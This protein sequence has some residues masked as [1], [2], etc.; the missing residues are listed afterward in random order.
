MKLI[1]SLFTRKE[2][3]QGTLSRK[4]CDAGAKVKM[5]L[6]CPVL[7]GCELVEK[8]L[9]FTYQG[10]KMVWAVN[11]DGVLSLHRDQLDQSQ[12]SDYHEVWSLSNCCKSNDKDFVIELV[13]VNEY[14]YCCCNQGRLTVVDMSQYDTGAPCQELQWHVTHLCEPISCF[15]V[16]PLDQWNV[17]CGGY[18]NNLQLYNLITPFND[19][20][21]HSLNYTI[22]TKISPYWMASAHSRKSFKEFEEFPWI[23]DIVFLSD[24][25]SRSNCNLCCVTQFGKILFY[26]TDISRYCVNELI[27]S[28]HRIRNLVKLKTG[29]DLLFIDSFGY[30]GVLRDDTLL[31]HYQVPNFGPLSGCDVLELDIQQKRD[32]E[33]ENDLL[34]LSAKRQSHVHPK[35]TGSGSLN[36]IYLVFST[37]LGEI[38]MIKL[39]NENDKYDLKMSLKMLKIG[40]YLPI[41]KFDYDTNELDE[42]KLMEI[43]ETRKETEKRVTR[44]H[45]IR[46]INSFI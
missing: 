7:E 29:T 17:A 24:S 30:I 44:S 38:K 13:M 23:T 43:N 12:L 2:C 26:N 27:L 10:D 11:K 22:I 41:L 14:L 28:N 25:E 39:A 36:P 40:E 46:R 33:D 1:Y 34:R 4:G 6:T 3:F 16:N 9:S 37:I 31:F 18:G 15:A 19:V 21:C 35:T 8:L 45:K 5:V 42:F 20:W 32:I